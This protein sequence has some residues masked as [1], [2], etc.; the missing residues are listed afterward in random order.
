MEHELETESIDSMLFYFKKLNILSTVNAVISKG[1]KEKKK[2][3]SWKLSNF[4]KYNE[5][6]EKKME[7]SKFLPQKSQEF[8]SGS[9]YTML[10]N[11]SHIMQFSSFPI[12]FL[13]LSFI[14]ALF[15]FNLLAKLENS[16]KEKNLKKET[17]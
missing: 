13:A 5:E 15:M 6:P 1:T 8:A 12:Y 11:E 9:K 7:F 10:Q 3:S 2:A 4:V 14:F 16:K 17:D